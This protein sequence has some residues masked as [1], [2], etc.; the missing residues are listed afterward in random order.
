MRLDLRGEIDNNYHTP[1]LKG[2]QSNFNSGLIVQH[3][4]AM[5]SQQLMHKL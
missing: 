5:H 3:T 2:S 4:T 1:I